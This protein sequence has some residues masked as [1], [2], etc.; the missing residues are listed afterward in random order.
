MI[1]ARTPIVLL[2]TALLAACNAQTVI[3]CKPNEAFD[4]VLKVCYK[5]DPGYKVDHATATCVVDPNW[6]PPEDTTGGED[7]PVVDVVT[8]PDTTV[9]PDSLEVQDGLDVS[10]DPGGNPDAVAPGAVGAACFMDKDCANAGVCFD[11]PGGYCTLLGCTGNDTC[12]EEAACLPLLENGTGCFDRCGGPGDCRPG[13]GCKGIPDA[14]GGAEL[15]CHPVGGEQLPAGAACEDH[16]ECVGDLSCVHLG[17]GFR[18]TKVGCDMDTPCP[19]N[20]ECIWLGWV[21]ACLPACETT[22][23]CEDLGDGLIC[24]ERE[25]LSEQEVLV[26][27]T[28]T[29]GLTIGSA[30]AFAAECQSGVCNLAVVGT[31]SDSGKPCSSDQSCQMGVCVSDPSVQSGVCTDYCSGAEFCDEGLCVDLGGA[32]PVCAPSCAGWDDD[33]GPEGMGLS[34][35]FGDLVSPPASGKY[36]CAL[37][38]SGLGGTPCEDDLQ[39]ADGDCYRP[40][41]EDGFCATLCGL[42]AD[43]PFGAICVQK[44]ADFVCMR[45]CAS[46][47]NCGDGFTCTTTTYSAMSI[48]IID[49]E[50]R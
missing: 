26:C 23:D 50:L 22:A 30:C 21:T 49:A 20:H 40:E 31:C 8:P 34:C 24:E 37:V 5:C 25:N 19:D 35:I 33:C 32:S 36:A 39:C 4:P 18:C 16:G 29:A 17:G 13:Y 6:K 44:D 10:E 3:T 27:V 28:P 14:T 46:N 15:I 41:D 7:T 2:L 1:H 12:P 47:L 48:C 42:G 11:W 43:C 38:T 9:P 45:R